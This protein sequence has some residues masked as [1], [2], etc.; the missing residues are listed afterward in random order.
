MKEFKYFV[1]N[2]NLSALAESESVQKV[3]KDWINKEIQNIADNMEIDDLQ[4]K[5]T[6]KELQNFKIINNDILKQFNN[7]CE[8]LRNWED[9]QNA[10]DVKLNIFSISPDKIVLIDDETSTGGISF[11]NETLDDFIQELSENEKSQL[12]SINNELIDCG[13]KPINSI[14]YDLSKFKN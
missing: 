8:I 3:L 13:I 14:N 2:D 4:G 10:Y 5:K 7:I 11:N 12:S 6:I 9:V 1:I